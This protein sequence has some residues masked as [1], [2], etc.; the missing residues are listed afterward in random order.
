MKLCAVLNCG[1]STYHLQKWMGDWCPNHKCNFGTSRCVCEPPFKLFPF[2]TER[3]NPRGRQ[4]WIDLINRSDPDTG[5]SWAPKSHSRV[6]SKHF[7]DGKPTPENP[8]PIENLILEPVEKPK[9]GRAAQT[10]RKFE[11]PQS[12]IC[13]DVIDTIETPCDSDSESMEITECQWKN[14]SNLC[15][16]QKDYNPHF[17]KDGI[18]NIQNF[19]INRT[20]SSCLRSCMENIHI[21]KVHAFQ[22]T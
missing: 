9:R 4:E 10:K 5:E 15:N 11:E 13:S 21:S 3:K 6:C 22:T 19:V 17:P 18:G 16:N 2:P 12:Q 8:N 20:V 7:P 1:N 14:D